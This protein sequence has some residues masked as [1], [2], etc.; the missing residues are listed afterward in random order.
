[1][2]HLRHLP[3][4]HIEASE[5]DMTN[6]YEAEAGAGLPSGS[7]SD[8]TDEGA[9]GA[10]GHENSNQSD[11][12]RHRMTLTYAEQPTNLSAMSP[13]SNAPENSVALHTHLNSASPNTSTAFPEN[14]SQ[15]AGGA[16]GGSVR[17]WPGESPLPSAP[18]TA[19]TSTTWHLQAAYTDN[20]T[21]PQS[22]V[23][24]MPQQQTDAVQRWRTERMQQ[25][26]H[27]EAQHHQ[28]LEQLEHMQRQRSATPPGS[29]ISYNVSTSH[30]YVIHTTSK[31]A[32]ANPGILLRPQPVAA[33]QPRYQQKQPP[34]PAD[35][36]RPRTESLED[37][38]ASEE[39]T[40]DPS[41]EETTEYEY[42]EEEDEEYEYY[43]EFF[44]EE[45]EEDEEDE[46]EPRIDIIEGQGHGRTMHAIL[47]G[48]PRS[49]TRPPHADPVRVEISTK[50]NLA[51]HE[52]SDSETRSRTPERYQREK[53]SKKKRDK[54]NSKREP[55]SGGTAHDLDDIG[56]GHEPITAAQKYPT[57]HS[58]ES[59]NEYSQP[60]RGAKKRQQRETEKNKARR[61]AVSDSDDEAPRRHVVSQNRVHIPR[62][63]E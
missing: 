39:E 26:Q 33:A 2:A 24:V 35:R 41:D 63:N 31:N 61:E 11:A 43:D 47:Y 37:S 7:S 17:A 48:L 45:V 16:P 8:H 56:E 44:E 58:S 59:D 40:T 9:S 27:M 51:S 34:P 13:P 6:P 62:K 50:P 12:S 3:R 38:D 4:E 1:M 55:Y 52:D 23:L 18:A 30:S 19:N 25:Q 60:S 46:E 22:E 21:P 29:S 57:P 5:D 32:A 15:I 20:V 54:K 28:A 53:A 42:Y 14:I 49:G 36:R 10:K